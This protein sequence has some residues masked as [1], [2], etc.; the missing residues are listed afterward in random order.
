MSKKDWNDE[1]M[2]LEKGEPKSNSVES[3][4]WRFRAEQAEARVDQLEAELR[5][6]E[7]LLERA[8]IAVFQVQTNFQSMHRNSLRLLTQCHKM[9]D[10]ALFYY[11]LSP[12]PLE[13]QRQIEERT[14]AKHDLVRALEIFIQTQSERERKDG[15]S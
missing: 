7:G 6:F 2:E 10:P 14:Q 3:W 4:D 9:L 8:K 11:D 12:N 15:S 1:M 5:E 13:R